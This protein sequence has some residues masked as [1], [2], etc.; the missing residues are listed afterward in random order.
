MFKRFLRVLNEIVYVKNWL[1]DK[2]I[3]IT[4]A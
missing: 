4:E 1:A 3:I 2:I